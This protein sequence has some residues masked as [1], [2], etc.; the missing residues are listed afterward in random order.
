MRLRGFHRSRGRENSRSRSRSTFS[1]SGE[2]DR[3]AFLSLPRGGTE[4]ERQ[5]RSFPGSRQQARTAID[6]RIGELPESRIGLSLFSTEPA[7]QIGAFI[8][9]A[10]SKD[11]P[12]HNNRWKAPWGLHPWPITVCERPGLSAANLLGRR[13]SGPLRAKPEFLW[14]GESRAGRRSLMVAS[15]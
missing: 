1:D 6:A 12:H 9:I 14:P 3:S 4:P 13:I 15:T 10:A 5:L 2:G 7:S 8:P 11:N